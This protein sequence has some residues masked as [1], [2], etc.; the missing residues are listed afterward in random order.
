MRVEPIEGSRVKAI[1]GNS[2][3][4]HLDDVVPGDVLH[5]WGDERDRIIERVD[6]R[7]GQ[8]QLH[9]K[10]RSDEPIQCSVWMDNS[11]SDKRTGGHIFIHD[12]KNERAIHQV[13]A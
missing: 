7:P 9:Y 8:T 2:I 12:L 10:F 1:V 4:V 3:M 13:D 6:R 5:C 11:R